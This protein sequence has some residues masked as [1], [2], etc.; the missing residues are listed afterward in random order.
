MAIARDRIQ[1]QLDAVM[2]GIA[3]GVI[4]IAEGHTTIEKGSR[5]HECMAELCELVT[6]GAVGVIEPRPP[7]ISGGTK[8]VGGKP[9]RSGR[10]KK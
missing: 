9:V 10:R 3:Q 1:Q 6:S 7:L 5:V 2:A 8:W 4:N